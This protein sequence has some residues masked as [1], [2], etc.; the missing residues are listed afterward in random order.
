MQV[1]QIIY[2]GY[3]KQPSP[4]EKSS[5][6]TVPLSEQLPS[7]SFHASS[8]SSSTCSSTSL[9]KRNPLFLPFE[10]ESS[11]E[12]S[13]TESEEV[14][15]PLTPDV[16]D[17]LHECAA[18]LETEFEET[19]QEDEIKDLIDVEAAITLKTSKN[20]AQQLQTE[21][22]VPQANTEDPQFKN[23]LFILLQKNGLHCRKLVDESHR[24]D[25]VPEG[26]DINLIARV[27][28]KH[29]LNL[30][31]PPQRKILSSTLARWAQYFKRLFPKTPTSCFY[32]YKY[33]P[34]RR[35]NGVIIQKRRAEGALQ[36]Q[37]FQ[38]RR[39]LIKEDRTVMLRRPSLDSVGDDRD[40]GPS[41]ILPII[42]GTWRVAGQEGEK[43][44]HCGEVS[45]TGN[46]FVI[47]FFHCDI[48]ITKLYLS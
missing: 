39:K 24:N 12:N 40:S 18:Q 16:E 21:P 17:F 33:E 26:R 6:E 15:D 38:E 47:I 41:N 2:Q 25:F 46:F 44:Q 48:N 36:V 29:L 3:G 43:V 14:K 19:E 10:I 1:A 28:A 32:S 34:S 42:I 5:E 13:N 45:T 11:E 37:L 8:S 27:T 23:P 7:T 35:R 9:F 31:T 22:A 20:I 30:A 4:S